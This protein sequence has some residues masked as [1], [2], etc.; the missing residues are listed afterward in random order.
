V[1]RGIHHY[2]LN[3]IEIYNRWGQLVFEAKPYL[4]DWDGT[5][6]G[7]LK[8]G[9][10]KLPVGTYLYILHLGDGSSIY[11]GTIYLNK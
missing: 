3:R 6:Q 2:P 10:D 9:G 11:K 1:I 7:G 8:M 4:N 5:A